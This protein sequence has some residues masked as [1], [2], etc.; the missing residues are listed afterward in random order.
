MLKNHKKELAVIIL[1]Y[2]EEIH[3][4]RCIS[5]ALRVSNNILVVDSYSTDRTVS[6]AKGM[7]ATVLQ[8]HWTNHSS[9]FNWALSN[10]K[11][12]CQWVLRIDADEYLSDALI[13]EIILNLKKQG[14]AINGIY[15][16]RKIIF[17]GKIIRFGG[18]GNISVLRLF[19]FGSGKAENRLMD[20]HIVINGKSLKFKGWIV[21]NNLNNLTWWISKHNKY[22]SLEAFEMLNLKYNFLETELGFSKTSFFSLVGFKKFTKLYIYSK[23][24][25]GIRSLFYFFFRYFLLLGF[26][27]G[28]NFHFLQGFWYRYLVDCKVREVEEYMRKFH[29]DILV[30]IKET[31]NI[32]NKV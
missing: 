9:Q 13:N 23:L 12:K 10:L 4:K 17:L 22:A 7:G 24:P 28:F 25:I 18:I 26:L 30:A 29:V 6:I 19:R 15:V 5:S 31:L 14:K 1:S 2:N 16:K 8:N 20:E 3:I 11:K 21:D 27:D 32:D